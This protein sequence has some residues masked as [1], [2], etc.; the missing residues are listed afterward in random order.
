MNTQNEERDKVLES[1]GKLSYVRNDIIN[2][3]DKKVLC[4]QMANLKQKK[5]NQ[6]KN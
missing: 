3:I 6:R 1:A 2:A 4:I 5:K